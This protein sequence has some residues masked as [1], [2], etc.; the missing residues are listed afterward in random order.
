MIP[1]KRSA[2]DAKQRDADHQRP[3]AELEAGK[4]HSD[5]STGQLLHTL[6]AAGRGR[7][8]SGRIVAAGD[9][10]CDA[11]PVNVSNATRWPSKYLW[12]KWTDGRVWELK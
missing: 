8:D 6:P 11:G 3:R 4:S 2:N 10:P 9:R 5:Y 1:D 7:L 12:K